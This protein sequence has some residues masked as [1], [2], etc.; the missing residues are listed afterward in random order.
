MHNRSSQQSLTWWQSLF[1]QLF[2]SCQVNQY[3]VPEARAEH[4]W[5][6]GCPFGTTVSEQGVGFRFIRKVVEVNIR[7]LPNLQGYHHF[8]SHASAHVWLPIT[9]AICSYLC[10]RY[11]W[12]TCL[13]IM[14]EAGFYLNNFIWLFTQWHSWSAKGAKGNELSWIRS[15]CSWWCNAIWLIPD[16][17]VH[18][19]L[20]SWCILVI[21]YHVATLILNRLSGFVV[22]S[23]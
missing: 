10:G 19:R 20:L 11:P 14:C 18:S 2:T 7:L 16:L 6:V 3:T 4:L 8:Q 17:L 23:L 13:C 15:S 22:G 21:K 9:S 1:N 12:P 5:A